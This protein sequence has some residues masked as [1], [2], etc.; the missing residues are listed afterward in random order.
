MVRGIGKNR[1]TIGITRFLVELLAGFEPATCWLRISCSTDWATV[2]KD[3]IGTWANVRSF[4]LQTSASHR[5]DKAL[6]LY[7]KRHKKQ[8]LISP[9][10]PPPYITCVVR[11]VSWTIPFLPHLSVKTSTVK[12]QYDSYLPCVFWR[13]VLKIFRFSRICYPVF[14]NP[15]FIQFS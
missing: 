4:E 12:I 10:F 7:H 13:K 5:P 2:A 3:E 15:N 8:V 14:P 1:V 11:S 6:L 9:G